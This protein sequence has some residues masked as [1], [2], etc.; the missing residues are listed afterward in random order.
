M[1]KKFINDIKTIDLKVVSVMNIGFIVS[2]LILLLACYVA[3]LY[4][5]Y[6]F[7]HVAY[8]VFLNLFKLSVTCVSSFFTCGVAINYLMK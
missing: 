1:I 3:V 4:N 7:S 5:T 8:L 6:P 2:L